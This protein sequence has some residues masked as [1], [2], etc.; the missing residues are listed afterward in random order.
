MDHIRFNIAKILGIVGVCAGCASA[1]PVQPTFNNKCGPTPVQR[2]DLRQF[3]VSPEANKVT[4]LRIFRSSSP[5]CREDLMR[6][7]MLFKNGTWSSDKVQLVLIAYK[8]AGVESRKTF[9]KFVRNDLVSLGIPLESTQI[10][11]LDKTYPVLAQSKN[12][13][14]DL[15]FA[16]WRAVPYGLVFAKDGRLAY[17]GHFT[18]SPVL[19]D[20]HYQFITE[21][22]N[23][24]CG[25][26]PG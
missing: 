13:R 11:F 3:N 21:L 16:D 6:I 20:N 2:E 18:A 14:G 10:V 19:Q 24:T 5:Y 9:D 22:Q 15:V 26:N 1:K 7:G 4:V 12:K 8:K 23:E 17:A 25:Q